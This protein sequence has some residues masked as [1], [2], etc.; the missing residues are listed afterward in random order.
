MP[1]FS[2][3]RD[4][5]NLLF[6]PLMI[7]TAVQL[8]Q[9]WHTLWDNNLTAADRNLILRIV[10]FLLMPVVVALHELGH[11]LATWG[12]GGQITKV[13]F[14][15]LWGY[16]VPQGQFS[17]DQIVLIFLAGNAMQFLVGLACLILAIFVLS[18]P[19]V[20]ILVYL[21]V[22]S[23]GEAIVL[24]PLMSLTGF[25]GDWTQIYSYLFNPQTASLVETIL[26]V[27]VACV[28]ALLWGIYGTAPKIWYAAKTRPGW[29]AEHEL[30][31]ARVLSEPNAANW[32]NLA[33]SYWRAGVLREAQSCIEKARQAEP[34]SEDVLFFAGWFFQQK[35]DY[36]K[37]IS[38]FDQ[39]LV[40]QNAQDKS[41]T[42]LAKVWLS[43]GSCQEQ[44]N[45]PKQAF[46]S[47]SQATKL[48]PEKA[49][50]HFFLFLVL[51]K[52]NRLEEANQELRVCSQLS[53]QDEILYDFY[54]EE[55]EKGQK[56]SHS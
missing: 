56:S 16:V 49:D 2:I 31:A 15:F 5:L 23:I 33:S 22:C 12:F 21:G 14:A 40:R 46:V 30:L 43:K 55:L 28:L 38:Y 54:L 48:V 47:Y 25:Y 41:P 52:L 18:P 50:G 37:A 53:W 4:L 9:N 34:G 20:A 36:R 42:F 8:K 13:H 39:I 17:L 1:P 32:L 10:I 27:H 45:D 3:S 44:L 29:S 11:A 19:V 7:I 6:V 51:R 24:Y 26:A 35:R